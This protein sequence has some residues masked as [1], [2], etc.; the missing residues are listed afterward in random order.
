[1]STMTGRSAARD[2]PA[3]LFYASRDRTREHLERHLSGYTGILQ[4]DAFARLQSPLSSQPKAPPDYRGSVLEPRAPQVLRIGRHLRERAAGQECDAD[5]ADCVGGR[6]THRRAVRHRARDHWPFGRTRMAERQQRSVV[7]VTA[8]LEKTGCAPSAPN[9]RA[10]PRS[11]RRSTTCSRV[12]PPSPDSSKTAASV[13]R[14]TRPSA[15]CAASPS[16]E[17]H[18]CSQDR[19]AGPPR[20]SCGC[21]VGHGPHRGL[22]GKGCSRADGRELPR[23]HLYRHARFER[24]VRRLGQTGSDVVGRISGVLLAGLAVQFIFDGCHR[25][26]CLRRPE[27][28]PG[29]R[30]ISA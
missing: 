19:S 28:R 3:A 6:Q 5:L 7:L 25:R 9:C 20:Q 29:P 2:P 8:A 17:N 30:W 18:D 22:A 13:F 16:V 12:G 27:E 1:M 26:R 4:A 21:R 23:F 10:M 24:L 14:T 15:R 11:P